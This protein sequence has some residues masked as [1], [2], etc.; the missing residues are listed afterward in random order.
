MKTYSFSTSQ[1]VWKTRYSFTPDCYASVDN[2]FISFNKS[3]NEQN[4]NTVCWVH[5]KNTTRNKFYN[6][7]Y[8]SVISVVS[9]ENPS[10][11]K[12]F[13]A[14]SIESNQNVFTAA[15]YAN[16]DLSDS[17]VTKK[18]MSIVP[19]FQPREEQLY[20][21]LGPSIVNSTKNVS[22][23]GVLG[24]KLLV[25]SQIPTAAYLKNVGL[26]E[27]ISA[28]T[29]YI[30]V[31]INSDSLPYGLSFGVKSG[32]SKHPYNN[33]EFIKVV[34]GQSQETEFDAEACYFNSVYNLVSVK[35]FNNSF[36]AVFSFSASNYSALWPS[37]PGLEL[38]NV[39]Y[40]VS[41]PGLNGD[42]MR[43]RYAVVT[44][45]TA[46]DGRPFELYA[47]NVDYAP[48]KLDTSS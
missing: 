21:E 45:Q 28:N 7:I 5:N 36:Y 39:I 6:Q 48:S 25:N 18:Q 33:I 3:S 15:V 43:G 16:L 8:P 10:Q 17:S 4:T 26:I 41:D 29:Y 30:P 12:V 40:A 44:V 2:Y 47:I 37:L 24:Q 14:V 27:N 32:F 35:F 46:S 20:A 1:N 38:G 19:F 9:N 11:E 42:S 13:N 34:N 23:V 31:Q 22:A